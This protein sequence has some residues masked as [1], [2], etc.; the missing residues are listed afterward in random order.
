MSAVI[1]IHV[2]PVKLK[3]ARGDRVQARVAKQIGV[4]RQ[5]LSQIENGKLRP[6][7]D[8]L[9]RLCLLYNVEIGD[10]TIAT[11]GKKKAA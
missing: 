9:A 1:K 6:N 10:L 4:S 3:R 8:L 5:H 7:A 11:N 2:S